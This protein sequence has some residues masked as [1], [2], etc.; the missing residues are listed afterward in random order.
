MLTIMAKYFKYGFSLLLVMLT[1]SSCKKYLD[2]NQNPN[3]P[4]RP[5]LNGLLGQ[6]T[7]GTAMNIYRVGD[8]TGNYVQ[9]LAS[10]NTAS[11]FDVYEPIDA[12]KQWTELYSVMTDL[13]DMD[14]LG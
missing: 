2:V 7:E 12:S 9:Y 5:P 6:V 4:T 1:A 8:V 10:S 13:Y 14:Q 11:E 3:S